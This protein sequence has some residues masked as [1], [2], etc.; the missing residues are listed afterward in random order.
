MIECIPPF[1]RS[2]A[3][4]VTNDGC[5]TT[6]LSTTQTVDIVSSSMITSFYG[7]AIEEKNAIEFS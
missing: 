7:K 6:L 2:S 5:R 4:Y 3:Q 1:P